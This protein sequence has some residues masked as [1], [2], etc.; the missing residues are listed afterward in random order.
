MSLAAIYQSFISSPTIGSLSDDATLQYIT[1]LTKTNG[2]TN[3]V[4]QSASQHLRKKKEKIIDA[5]ENQDAL[6]VEVETTI[7]FVTSGGMYLPGLDDNFISDRTVTFPV[8]HVVYFAPNRKIQQIRLSWDQGALL[9]DI[10]LIGTRGRNWPIMDGQEQSRRIA[11][12]AKPVGSSSDSHR[13]DT[14]GNGTKG[15]TRD[16][17]ASL[18]LFGPRETTPESS[19]PPFAPTPRASAK[20]PQ[21][22]YNELFVGNYDPESPSL[23]SKGRSF[24]GGRQSADDPLAPEADDEHRSNPLPSIPSNGRSFAGGKQSADD[25]LAPQ[26][27]YGDSSDAVP[28][29]PSNGRSFAGGKRSGQ[30]QGAPQGKSAHPRSTRHDHFAFGDEDEPTEKRNPAPAKPNTSR[31]ASQWDFE[32]TTTP[33]KPTSK[34]RGQDVRHFGWSDDEVDD[35][36]PAKQKR[37]AQPRR[38]AEKH[39]EFL[40]DGTPLEK[41][42]VANRQKGNSQ[43][44]GLGLYQ[45]N[46][47][48]EH[49]N[50]GKKEVDAQPLGNV[51]NIKNQSKYFDNHFSMADESPA[52]KDKPAA[53]PAT[54]DHKAA[55]KMMNSSWDTYG[56]SPDQSKKENVGNGQK[57]IN[58]DGAGRA[59]CG[60][61]SMGGRSGVA[62]QWGF[63]DESDGEQAAAPQIR[64]GSRKQTAPASTGGGFWDF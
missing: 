40:D 29:L 62:R 31:N 27:G 20:P 18:A 52:S 1:T 13:A 23:P 39:F 50:S 42:K 3:I 58:G 53:K 56:E 43:N 21:R 49:P 5:I 4:K 7:E 61:D 25:P 36:A 35:A 12:S 41:G 60:G 57:P 16:P 14:T 28:S 44:S 34:V 26:A 47:Y 33:I 59:H 46:V 10:G 24:A 9:K 51:T 48:D 2:A 55:V 54:A 38:D 64:P 11:T 22:D 8:T 6:F 15:M 19:C 32:D 45:N 63:G 30:D 37:P 17:H